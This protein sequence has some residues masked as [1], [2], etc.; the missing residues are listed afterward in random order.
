MEKE[1][2]TLYKDLKAVVSDSN[3]NET[4]EILDLEGKKVLHVADLM[5]KASS[6]ERA[7]VPAIEELKGK[8]VASLVVIDRKEG[9]EEI[10]ETLGVK[11]FSLVK[12]DDSLFTEA[13]KLG[14]INESQL[15]MLR[16]YKEN[17]DETM[18]DF[19]INHPE[20]LQEALKS[21]AKTVGRARNC[22]DNDLYNLKG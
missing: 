16:K 21:D 1:H 11:A 6:Y 2:I 22:I 13:L 18:R 20:F 5:N 10:I 8:M 4:K 17:P 19:L 3:F 15:Q 9:G 12:V 7:W 14:I